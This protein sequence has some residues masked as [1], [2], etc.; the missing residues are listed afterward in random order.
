RSGNYAGTGAAGTFVISPAGL[1][2]TTL[3]VRT[4]LF[5]TGTWLGNQNLVQVFDTA[6]A[7]NMILRITSANKLA[8][9]LNDGANITVGTTTIADSTIMMI[10]IKFV[11]SATV[12]GVEVK[13]NN[14]VE[15]TS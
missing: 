8:W 9:A 5:H 6:L 4:S 3:G 12:G 1:N 13:I 11:R 10:D 7:H 14:V 15:F 2:Q